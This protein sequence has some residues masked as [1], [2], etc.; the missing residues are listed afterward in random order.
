MH[1]QV[2]FITFKIA[3]PFKSFAIWENKT[4]PIWPCLSF[5]GHNNMD[6]HPF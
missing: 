4:R 6:I 3:E 2:I 1:T 5:P